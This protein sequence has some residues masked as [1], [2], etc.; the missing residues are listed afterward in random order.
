MN[1]P[2]FDAVYSPGGMMAGLG[3]SSAI[4][5]NVN[6]YLE[7]KSYIRK[8]T[9]TYSKEKTELTLVP[10]SLGVR[11]IF[12]FG[13]LNPYA[14]GG[15]DFYFYYEDN[16]IGTIL[17]YTNGYHF[18]AG[19]YLQFFKNVPVLINLKLKYTTARAEE[20]GIK[21]QLGGLEYTASLVFSF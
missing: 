20:D 3:L 4:V 15:A 18:M 16:P 1:E 17:N 21:I 19:T 9:L 10:I 11:Y 8:G 2:R 12:P 5:S 13:I 14:G 6:F 7:I